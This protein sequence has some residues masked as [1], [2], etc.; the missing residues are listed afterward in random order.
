MMVEHERKFYTD[1]KVWVTYH[2]QTFIDSLFQRNGEYYWMLH[3]S[4]QQYPVS[5]TLSIVR[6]FFKEERRV[7][8]VTFENCPSITA[9]EDWNINKCW[10]SFCLF[11][12][13]VSFYA[14]HL[15]NPELWKKRNKFLQDL[16]KSNSTN[17]S[18]LFQGC[19]SQLNWNWNEVQIWCG[20]AR[21]VIRNI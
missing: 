15:R 13:F 5:Q 7:R 3:A 17:I 19:T 20:T 12:F 6:S 14:K 2:F 4:F 9:C 8:M 11:H 10:H 1:F 18:Y 21:S 16:W